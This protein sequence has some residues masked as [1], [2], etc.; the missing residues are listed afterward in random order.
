MPKG[1]GDGALCRYK[2]QFEDLASTECGYRDLS[3][4]K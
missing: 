1:A 4:F 3:V 2:K